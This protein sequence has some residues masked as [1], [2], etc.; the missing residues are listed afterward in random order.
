MMDKEKLIEELEHRKQNLNLRNYYG[1]YKEELFDEHIAFLNKLINLINSMKEE[2]FVD[3]E[4][5]EAKKRITSEY[6]EEMEK[7]HDHKNYAY[8]NGLEKGFELGANWQKEKT[9]N[10]ACE[11][12]QQHREEVKTEDNG[13]AGWIDNEFI[14]N[15]S[16]AMKSS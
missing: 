15:F 9:I 3:G 5:E 6:M 8:W 2:E 12:L 16:K 11:Y 4:L 10:S 13:I 14:D 1:I 7:K